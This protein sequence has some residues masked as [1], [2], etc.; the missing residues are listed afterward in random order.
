M[1]VIASIAGIAQAGTALS[2][3]IYTLIHATR[4]APKGVYDIA[5]AVGD[6]SIILRELRRVLRDCKNIIRRS[7]LRQ[8]RS[9]MRRIQEIHCEIQDLLDAST[10]LARLAWVFRRSKCSS[11]LQQIDG[12]RVSINMI[13]HMMNFALQRKLRTKLEKSSETGAL[14]QEKQA[15]KEE[16]DALR[17]QAE[18]LVQISHQSICEMTAASND[19]STNMDVDQEDEDETERP[20][21]ADVDNPASRTG[22]LQ[23]HRPKHSRDTAQ[24]LYDLPDASDIANKLLSQ[25]TTLSEADI[26]ATP[27]GLPTRNNTHSEPV[28]YLKDAVGRKFIL[29][30]RLARLW[31]IEGLE[32][33]TAAKGCA[34]GL[35]IN[36]GGAAPNRVVETCDA[37]HMDSQ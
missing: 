12:Y 7:L 31:A 2:K 24:W 28:I 6:Q 18:T 27:S 11:L 21:S 26:E 25:W 22:S 33:R 4:N 14:N 29:P 1:E 32:I 37:A 13:L 15:A 5:R 20:V 9:I 35:A 19:L 16:T 17:Q 3:A 23:L 34:A 30:W 36:A 10:G 8:V